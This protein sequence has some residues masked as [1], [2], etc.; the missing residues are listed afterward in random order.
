MPYMVSLRTLPQEDSAELIYALL[1]SRLKNESAKR[2]L[3]K[4]VVG[5]AL[6]YNSPVAVSKSLKERGMPLEEHSVQ[7][8]W[9]WAKKNLSE[10]EK[11]IGE[12]AVPV[13]KVVDY[14]LENPKK[15]KDDIL[16]VLKKCAKF[17]FIKKS[18]NDILNK[19]DLSQ[20]FPNNIN[21]ADILKDEKKAFARY[22][23]AGIPIC[24]K[25]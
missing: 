24:K 23:K 19:R 13:S 9:N 20:E 18:E 1:K 5:G 22:E 11:L 7:W 6:M 4:F 12:H 17:S 8:A 14:L 2:E 10:G 3:L 21:V 15:N 16:N 25:K